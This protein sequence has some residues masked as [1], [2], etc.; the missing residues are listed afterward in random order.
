MN[1]AQFRAQIIEYMNKHHDFTQD[2]IMRMI[3][4]PKIR[5]QMIGHMLENQEFMEEF[6]KAMGEGSNMEMTQ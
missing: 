5:F 2:M 6:R 4:D 3:D 1:D